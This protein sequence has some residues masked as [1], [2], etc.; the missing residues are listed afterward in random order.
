MELVDPTREEVFARVAL[1]SAADADL[2]VAAAQRAFETFSVTSVEERIALIDRVIDVY[3]SHIDEFSD[4]K[5]T[6]NV[7]THRVTE[8]PRGT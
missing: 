1:G 8:A 2:A 3:E 4:L 5:Q 7:L 6:L